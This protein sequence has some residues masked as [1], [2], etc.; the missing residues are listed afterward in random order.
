MLVHS[1]DCALE[2]AQLLKTRM[3]FEN[4]Y[5]GAIEALKTGNEENNKFSV[6]IKL[7]EIVMGLNDHHR[8]ELNENVRFRTKSSIWTS[9]AIPHTHTCHTRRNTKNHHSD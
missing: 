4:N 8:F 6:P 2:I 3:S 7:W 5:V 1:F 9:V